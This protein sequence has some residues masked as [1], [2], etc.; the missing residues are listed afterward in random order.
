[1]AIQSVAVTPTGAAAVPE[2]PFSARGISDLC[3]T[4]GG[5]L[6]G[7]LPGDGQAALELRF[8]NALERTEVGSGQAGRLEVTQQ[9]GALAPAFLV[10]PLSFP[11]LLL[12]RTRSL[13]LL[14]KA[15]LSQ[16]T[17]PLHLLP[18]LLPMLFAQFAGRVAI[19][20]KAFRRMCEGLQ[21]RGRTGVATQEGRQH[22][23]G[24]D[25]RRTRLD[26]GLDAQL[27]GPGAF[28][29]QGREKRRQLLSTFRGGQHG[30]TRRCGQ[31]RGIDAVLALFDTGRGALVGWKGC[32][33]LWGI[34]AHGGRKGVNRRS[35]GIS[36][37]NRGRIVPAWPV[38]RVQTGSDRTQGCCSALQTLPAAS[39][40]EIVE[41]RTSGVDR[42][43]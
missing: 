19:Q 17:T 2:I 5:P 37:S 3:R 35:P 42:P 31:L 36:R 25:P 13:P 20:V 15:L 4:P 12:C 43:T 10:R 11:F 1:M 8:G 40:N 26:V 9:T 28:A 38:R 30:R 41:C 6:R 39:I 32:G 16:G 7:F 21:V 18:G 23:L 33:F 27:E 24:E 29:E 22:R 34:R 14:G